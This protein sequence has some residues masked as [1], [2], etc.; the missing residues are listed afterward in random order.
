MAASW[1]IKAQEAEWVHPEKNVQELA[2]QSIPVLKGWVEELD[3]LLQ[4]P[5]QRQLVRWGYA[6]VA[7]LRVTAG[8]FPGM[9]FN[10]LELL[11]NGTTP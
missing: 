3:E 9:F 1:F 10:T 8:I 4:N 2:H 5:V 6:C 11:I 7:A